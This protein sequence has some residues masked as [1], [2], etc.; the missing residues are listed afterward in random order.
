MNQKVDPKA[1]GAHYEQ[2]GNNTRVNFAKINE[3]QEI[4]NLIDI[5][6]NSYEWFIKDGIAAVLKESSHIE[7]HTGTIVLDYVGHTLEKT[8]KYS[9]G[10][11]K[12]RDAT[13]A[14]PLKINCRLTNTQTQDIKDTEI[15]FGDFPLMTDTGT[16][17]INGAERV[18]VS[19]LVRSPGIYFSF[20]MDKAGNKLF[21]GTVMP[22]RGPWVEYESDANDVIYVRVDKGKKFPV[23]TLIR[24]FGIE[25]DEQIK[26]VFGEDA[27][28]L[29]TLEKDTSTSRSSALVELYKKLRPGEPATTE[30]AVAH[31]DNLFFNERT[32]DL[33]RVGRYKY[34]KK[35]ALGHRIMGKILTRPVSDPLTGE[36]LADAGETL[37]R[38]KAFEIEAKGVY[39]VYLNIDEHEIRV[40]SNGMVDMK[41]FVSFDPAEVGIREWVKFSVLCEILD[42]CESEKEIKEAC[43]E[44][45]SELTPNTICNEDLFSSINYIL[46]LYY[47]IGTTDDID[48][49]GNRRIRCVGELL[50]NQLRIG[51]TR[52]ERAIKE[53]MNMQNATEATPQSL[54]NS[55][56]VIAAIREFFG[57]SPLSQFMD[58]SNPLAEITHK[59]RLSALGPGGLTRDR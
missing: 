16:F 40:F 31:I 20:E 10:E 33:T 19:Q 22:N 43:K 30:G 26:A 23:T 6:L 14:A 41:N 55:R 45:L 24:A 32:Y 15:F 7:D 53:R 13:Y 50:Q 39:E 9:I 57:S 37:S 42:S 4:P 1:V 58:Q 38:E 46:C 47:G 54:I 59:R 8:P 21:S 56:P 18:V 11:C 52:M 3:V 17:I 49:L 2:L 51:F 27:R 36:I 28:I 12:E 48:H 35:L 5:Q 34:N 29:S 44:R 25:T